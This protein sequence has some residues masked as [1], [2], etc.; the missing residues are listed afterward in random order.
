MIFILSLFA[1]TSDKDS[2]DSDDTNTNVDCVD[3]DL[4]SAV[5]EA[6]QT[7]SISE[8]QGSYGECGQQGLSFMSDSGGELESSGNEVLLSWTAP[9]SSTY[10]VYT[11]GSDYDTTLTVLDGCGGSSLDCDDD[12]G[13]DLDSVV[14]FSAN[15]GQTYVIILDSYSS[16]DYGNW[17]LNIVEG[18]SPNID[19]DTGWTD[20]GWVVEDDIWGCDVA[21]WGLC[22]DMSQYSGWDVVSA[23]ETCAAV[24]TTYTVQTTFIEDNFGCPVDDAVGECELPPSSDFANSVTAFYDQGSFDVTSA[25]AACTYAN[26]EFYAK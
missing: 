20:S 6:V 16:S 5:G 12:G 10:T 11:Y 1:C 24:A 26:G 23:Q 25:E 18:S 19:F 21:E 14:T 2:G 9:G 3:I 17:T 15:A 7:G 22:Y 13:F 8:G 4:G